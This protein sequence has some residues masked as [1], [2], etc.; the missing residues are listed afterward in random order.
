MSEALEPGVS[1]RLDSSTLCRGDCLGVCNQGR[2]RRTLK[3]F[4]AHVEEASALRQLVDSVER[5]VAQRA[6]DRQGFGI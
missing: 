6:V 3:E 5:D 1:P 2:C 4:P